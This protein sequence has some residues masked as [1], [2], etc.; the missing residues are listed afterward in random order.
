MPEQ[1]EKR[2]IVKVAYNYFQAGKW[3]R[4]LEEYKK[5][6][7]IDPMDFLVHNMMA[8]IYIRKGEKEQAIN[9]FLKAASLLRATNSMEKAIQAYNHVIRL[10]PENKEARLKI[11]EIVRTRLVEVDDYMRRGSLKNALE[12]CERLSSKLPEHQQIREKIEEIEKCIAQQHQTSEAVSKSG[13]SEAPQ[14]EAD[15]AAVAEMKDILKN[16]EVVNNLLAMAEYYENKQSFE[17]AVEAYITVLRFQPDNIKAQN[18]LRQIYRQITRKDKSNQVWARISSER[19]KAVEQAKRLAKTKP[20]S[21]AESP[22]ARL[23][24]QA[25]NERLAELNE[26][27]IAELEKLRL[28][29]EERLRLAVKDRRA[30]ERQRSNISPPE[31][32]VPESLSTVDESNRTNEEKDQNIQVLLTQAQMYIHQNML[33]EAMR[34][35]QNILELDPPNKE[36]RNI[37]KQIYDKKNL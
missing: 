33:I 5:L 15:K 12:I 25:G 23:L 26:K 27:N 17:E 2:I 16:E 10:D 3:D 30:R 37:L 1:E 4:A 7:A 8:E 19:Q 35:A 31:P 6:I 34:L 32:A 11:E 13:T 29:A 9:E 14:T 36:V 22:A 24:N 20:K 28:Q 21:T 18:K